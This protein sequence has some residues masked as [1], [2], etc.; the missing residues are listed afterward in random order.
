MSLPIPFRRLSRSAAIALALAAGF[1]SPASAQQSTNPLLAKAAAM[2][3]RAES[4][5]TGF[6]DRL[7]DLLDFGLPS[8]APAGDLRFYAHPKF[9][10]LIHE[11]YFRLPLGARY[12]V[13]EDVEFNTELSGYF[14]HGLRDS[15][16]NG[17]YQFLLGVQ[18]EVVVSQ[19]IGYSFGVQWVTPLSRPP[20]EITDGLRHTV[21]TVTVTKTLV[22]RQ[23]LIGFA[24]LGGDFLDHTHLPVNF[25]M[26]E[27]RDNSLILTLGLA[28]EWRR[29]HVILRIFDG[30]TAPVSR[31]T[32]NV[33]GLRPS[34][35]IP[36]LRRRDGVPRAT[37]TFEGRAIWGPDGFEK[38][39]NTSV[40]FDLHYRPTRRTE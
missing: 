32:Q 1:A 13:N 29:M 34:L 9:G 20:Y 6:A 28:R 33:W 2:Q 15:V 25:R 18:R 35:G 31:T 8:F 27:L 37:A 40:R 36:L 12:K 5:L 14:T 22:A 21:P 39:I 24:T 4:M 38:G 7:P 19:E 3:E 23:G 30:N 17:L 26:N 11:D 10:D 16:G